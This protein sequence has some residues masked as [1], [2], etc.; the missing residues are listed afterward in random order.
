MRKLKLLDLFSGIGGF[1]LAAKRLGIETV[2]FWEIDRFPQSVLK[3]RYPNIPIIDDIR[4]LTKETFK[5]TTGLDY[6]D[7]ICRG[8]KAK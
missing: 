6:V 8:S 7:I 1:T 4:N 2:A 5:S 3:Y